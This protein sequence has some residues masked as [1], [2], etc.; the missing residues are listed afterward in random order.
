MDISFIREVIKQD[1]QYRCYS[2][3]SIFNVTILSLGGNKNKNLVWE[4]GSVH[5]CPNCGDTSFVAN[6]QVMSEFFQ[7]LVKGNIEIKDNIEDNIELEDN[8]NG[9]F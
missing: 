6:N 7:K 5:Y 1:H 3:N 2:C 8:A 4:N 9:F